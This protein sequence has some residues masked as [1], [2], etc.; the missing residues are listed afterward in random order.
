MNYILAVK[1]LFCCFLRELDSW[2]KDKHK[3]IKD[4]PMWENSVPGDTFVRHQLLLDED[5]N[6]LPPLHIKF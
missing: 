6:L 2:E 5:K 3:R 4:W 1:L